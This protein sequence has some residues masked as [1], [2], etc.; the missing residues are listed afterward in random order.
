M[1][2]QRGEDVKVKSQVRAY[3]PWSHGRIG[4][5][6]FQKGAK[7]SNP[8]QFSWASMAGTVIEFGMAEEDPF[9]TSRHISIKIGTLAYIMPGYRSLMECGVVSASAL[10]PH[11]LIR[12]RLPC[13][14]PAHPSFKEIWLRRHK[15]YDVAVKTAGCCSDNKR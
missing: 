1:D 7:G 2:I 5:Y 13:R 3:G 10:Q 12:D 9:E 14:P 4:D 15:D 8:G 11:H 6:E